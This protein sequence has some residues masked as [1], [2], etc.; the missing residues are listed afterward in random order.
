[1]LHEG[2]HFSGEVMSLSEGDSTKYQKSTARSFLTL[3]SPQK[4]ENKAR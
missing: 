4:T 2:S 3:E 1:M